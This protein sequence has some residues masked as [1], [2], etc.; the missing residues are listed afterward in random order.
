MLLN[1][2]F[3]SSYSQEKTDTVKFNNSLFIKHIVDAGESLKI[4]SK[5]YNVT[6]SQ[7]LEANEMDRNLYYNQTL[8]IPVNNV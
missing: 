6:V 2:W 5:K 4:I 3:L 7:I 8:Y 1:F